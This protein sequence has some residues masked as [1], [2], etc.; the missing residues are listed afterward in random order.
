M[1]IPHDGVDIYLEPSRSPAISLKPTS[2]K[3]GYTVYGDPEMKE[4]LY[5][6]PLRDC[7]VSHSLFGLVETYKCPIGQFR[8]QLGTFLS[9]RLRSVWR[10]VINIEMTF[11]R[12]EFIAKSETLPMQFTEPPADI[13]NDFR[14]DFKRHP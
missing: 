9:D 13:T 5:H 10:F 3:V 2:C 12:D 8:E 14:F 7:I 11:P 4:V 6:Q 1:T